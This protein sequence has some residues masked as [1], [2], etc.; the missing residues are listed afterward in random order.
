MNGEMRNRKGER[1]RP[2]VQRISHFSFL[3]S[4]FRKGRDGFSLLELLLYITVVSVVLL[5]SVV[6][7]LDLL[8]TRLKAIALETVNQNERLALERVTTALRNANQIS[9]SGSVFDVPNGRLSLAMPNVAQ[10]PT[11]IDVD[12]GVLRISEGG[13]AAVPLTSSTVEVTNFTLT[14]LNQ[15]SAEGVRIQLT[16][17]RTNPQQVTELKAQQ[18]Y[19]TAAIIR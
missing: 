8:R 4:H 9:A 19:V 11:V 5:V 15:A 13:G 10:D 12:S 6:L 1:L 3:I 18:T 14:R 17:R 16:L 2:N 7:T